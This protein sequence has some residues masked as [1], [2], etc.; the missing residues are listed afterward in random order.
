MNGLIRFSLRNPRAITVLM[1]TVV[2]TGAVVLGVIPG[3]KSLIPADI[4]PV[5]RSPA[6]QVLTFYNG[7]P[8]R[9]VARPWESRTA[10][11]TISPRARG[12]SGRSAG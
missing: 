8:A 2:I 10:A 11:W 4:L 9:S 5:Y 6:V 1:L 12:R 7:M 3:T